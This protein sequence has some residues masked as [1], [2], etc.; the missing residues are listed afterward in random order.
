MRFDCYSQNHFIRYGDSSVVETKLLKVG[1][2][3]GMW[4]DVFKPGIPDGTWYLCPPIKKPD[5]SKCLINY[6]AKV[7]IKNGMKQGIL[8]YTYTDYKTPQ[9]QYNYVNDT[10]HGFYSE[11]G[12][13]KQKIEEGYYNKGEKHGLFINYFE[14]RDGKES[15]KE[16]AFFHYDTLIYWQC[17]NHYEKIRA[18]GECIYPEKKCE[19]VYFDTLETIY[20]RGYF[21]AKQE[22]LRVEYFDKN[23]N[24]EKELIGDFKYS[25]NRKFSSP[26]LRDY[27]GLANTELL[28]GKI[29]LYSD[30]VLVKELIK[31]P[32]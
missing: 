15:P 14:K 8:E 2:G 6:M 13:M 1:E 28:N 5:T 31:T 20:A 16:I 18:K 21:N 22:L 17:Y 23:G 25:E 29:R 4:R 26:K 3:G 10:L 12:A 9:F 11:R 30:G 19:C 27:V 24:I 32:D 7:S